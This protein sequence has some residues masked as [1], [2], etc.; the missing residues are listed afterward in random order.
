MYNNK[1]FFVFLHVYIKYFTDFEINTSN[2]NKMWSLQT[3]D[4]NQMFT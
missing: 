2:K 4:Q 3:Y 1:I